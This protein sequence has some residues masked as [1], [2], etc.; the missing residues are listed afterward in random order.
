M[1]TLDTALQD[2][3]PALLALLDALPLLTQAMGQTMPMAMG[4]FQALCSLRKIFTIDRQDFATYRMRRGH[5]Y[6]SVEIVA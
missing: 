2:T 5:R 4:G 6:Y 1:L 3:M